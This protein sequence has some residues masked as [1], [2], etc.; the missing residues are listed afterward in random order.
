MSLAKDVINRY[1]RLK[2]ARGTWEAH[3]REVAKLTMPR[4]DEFQIKRS[5]GQ[6][7]NQFIYDSTAPLALERFAAAMES[8]L[9]PRATRWH[10]LRASDEALNRDHEVKAWFDEAERVLFAARYAPQANFASQQHEVYMSLGAF[11]TGSLFVAEQEGVGLHYRSTHLSRTYID[12]NANGIVDTVYRL[13]EPT[14]RQIK[15]TFDEVPESIERAVRED[16]DPNRKFDVIHCVKPRMERDTMAGDA[17]NMPYMSVYVLREGEHVLRD[18]GFEEFPY[19][20]SRYVTAPTEM[21]GRSP[22]IEVLADI[23]MINSISKTVI[24]Q[25]HLTLRPP[26]LAHDDGV[27]DQFSLQPG[28]ITVGGI[29]QE[30]RQLVQPFETRGRVD[31]GMDFQDKIG[32]RINDAFLVSLF[33]ILTEHPQMTATEALLRA[34]EKGALLSPTIGRQ[35]S[36]ALGPMIERE[37]AILTRAGQLPPMPDLLIEARGEYDIEYDSPLTKMKRVDEISGYMQTVEVIAPLAQMDPTIMDNF[38]GDEIARIVSEANGI[39]QRMLRAPEQVAQIR[40]ARA[41]QQAAQAAIEA[42][43][44][45]G[46]AVRDVTEAGARVADSQLAANQN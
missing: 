4:S 10:H 41:Q 18:G 25:A 36:E 39:P 26:I 8:M 23:K 44:P 29:S 22:A 17:A 40:Q 21:Y 20:V 24:E 38:D 37:L 6:K 9:T 27:A 42:A 16:K 2:A 35:Q 28:A 12:E 33:Q 46:R 5:P 15:Q 45:V 11:G 14:A 32:E 34:Q 3:W 19:L 43:Q 1:D 30:G 7:R 31:I 13:W